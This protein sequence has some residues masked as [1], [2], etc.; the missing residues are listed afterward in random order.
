MEEKLMARWQGTRDTVAPQQ[1][2]NLGPDACR[3]GLS[4]SASRPLGMTAFR[5]TKKK[6]CQEYEKRVEM[7]GLAVVV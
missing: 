3:C 5:P 6:P 4:R 2:A 7:H 1:L